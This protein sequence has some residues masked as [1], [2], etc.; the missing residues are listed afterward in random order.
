[1]HWHET[2]HEARPE[3]RAAKFEGSIYSG[4]KSGTG[5]GDRGPVVVCGH[6]YTWGLKPTGDSAP[7][8]TGLVGASLLSPWPRDLLVLY[9]CMWR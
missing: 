6:E 4:L 5:V 3:P 9:E 1:M 8:A 2:M 7:P